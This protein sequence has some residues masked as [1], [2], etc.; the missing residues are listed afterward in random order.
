[1][2]YKYEEVVNEGYPQY[3][4]KVVVK[5]SNGLSLFGECVELRERLRKLDSIIDFM[6]RYDSLNFRMEQVKV[7]KMLDEKMKE[8]S[9]LDQERIGQEFKVNNLHK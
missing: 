2:E 6:D 3:N 9:S 4:I 8:L 7:R 1:M 5:E